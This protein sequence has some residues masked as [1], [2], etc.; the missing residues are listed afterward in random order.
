[1]IIVLKRGTEPDQIAEVLR[2]AQR[3]GLQCRALVAADKPVLHVLSGNTRRARKLLKLERVQALVATSGPRVRVEGRRFFP[4]HFLNWSSAA[5]MLIATLVLL[6][7]Q[8]P[9]G[10]GEAPGTLAGQAAPGADVAGSAGAPIVLPWYVAWLPGILGSGSP[11][12]AALLFAGLLLLLLALPT[13]DRR[14]I[15]GKGGA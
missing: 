10:V 1:M 5:L 12:A 14:L 3:R 11:G 9:P 7:G 4:Y 2:E 8:F 6:A 15:R 13:L